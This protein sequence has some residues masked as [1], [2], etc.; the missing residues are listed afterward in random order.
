[1]LV[2]LLVVGIP[3]AHA[4]I[5]EISIDTVVYADEGSVTRLDQAT[6]PSELVGLTCPV[7]AAA[8]NQSSVHPGNDLIVASDGDSMVLADVE[9]APGAVTPGDGTL[10]LG[11]TITVSLRMGRDGVFSGGMTVTLGDCAPPTTTTTSSSTTTT[12][13][14]TSTSTTTT[15]TAGSQPDIAIDKT[16]TPTDYGRDGIGHFTIKVTNIGPVPL[17]DVHVTDEIA[18][19]VDP[20]SACAQPDLPDLA[21]GESYEYT[22]SVGNLNGISPFTN[23]ATAIGT[24][25]NGTQVTD[26]DD[27]T[28]FPPVLATTITQP[29][30]TLPPSTVPPT[31][32][33][34]GAS[35]EQMR[36]F[37]LVG[38]FLLA[39]GV[40]VLGAAALIAKRSH[41]LYGFSS[42]LGSR[43]IT[44]EVE[45][46]PKV[47]T[48]HI[49]LRPSR[50][51]H[52]K[53]SD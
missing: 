43:H 18:S 30:S 5:V 22:C 25:P 4:A 3:V 29:P 6:T 14:S 20:E 50:P 2:A 23:E 40:A 16:A 1:M 21:V 19:I 45:P 48:F 24:G 15:T 38:L 46:L 28:V 53:G 39:A 47:R 34:T 52:R 35:F 12:S 31:L 49:R 26:T 17:T 27:A 13:T 41:A 33:V 51:D 32:P 9:R 37:G 42:R 36:S 10:T 11:E 7:V 8:E 44:L